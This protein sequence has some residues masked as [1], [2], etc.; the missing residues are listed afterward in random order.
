M[1]RPTPP[2]AAGPGPLP[3]PDVPEGSVV[4]RTKAFARAQTLL[5][6]TVGARDIA[7]V[8]GPPGCGKTLAVS[9]F[10]K[11]HPAA[12]GRGVFWL[13]MPPRPAAKEVTQ[14]LLGQLGAHRG[15]RTP[16]YE[17][18][19]LLSPELE[20]SGA[21][22]VVDE[23]H[24]LHRDGLQ[25]LRYYHDRGNNT[26]TLILIGSS[27]DKTLGAAPELDSRVYA[28][29]KFEPLNDTELLTSLRAWHPVLATLTPQTLIDI[30]RRVGRGNW[31][32]WEHFLNTLL[33]LHATPTGRQRPI[34]DLVPAALAQMRR[35]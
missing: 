17:L 21:V 27:I 11:N 32:R 31:R 6:A 8:Y 19:E 3:G 18:T 26:W 16:H 30:D 22:V 4:V 15:A 34:A 24:H 35:P 23:A 20:G 29:L 9:Y 12:E 14:R 5:G 25:Q 1:T 33:H 28:W 10:T 2:A 7:A 13:Q